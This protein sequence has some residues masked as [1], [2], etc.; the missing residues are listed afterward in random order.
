MSGEDEAAIVRIHARINDIERTMNT[1]LRGVAVALGKLEERVHKQP[2]EALIELRD[3]VEKTKDR[4]W[5]VLLKLA[6][7]A[8]VG[9]AV[10]YFLGKT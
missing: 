4:G 7:P 2:C 6:T 5:Q 8:S 9:A 3:S 1:E 10:A